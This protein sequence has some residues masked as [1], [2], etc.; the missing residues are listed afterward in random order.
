[1]NVKTE[2]LCIIFCSTS[3][4]FAQSASP[5][6]SIEPVL[7]WNTMEFNSTITL[8]MSSAGLRLPTGRTHGEELL[9]VEFPRIVSPYLFSIPVDS[10]TSIET[11]IQQGQFSILDM[12]LLVGSAKKSPAVLDLAQNSL[13]R[14][15]TVPLT[16]LSALMVRHHVPASLPRPLIPQPSRDYT[17]LIIFAQG[18]LPIYGRQGS[19]RITPCIFPKIW[20]SEGSLIYEKNMVIPEIA[21]TRGIVRYSTIGQVLQNTPSGIA[22]ELQDLV[23]ERPLRILADKVFGKL[24]TDPVI[25][26][27]DALVLLSSDNNR[28]LLQEGRVVI[29]IAQELLIQNVTVSA[30]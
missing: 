24:P 21:K 18:T 27:D 4:L 5:K 20:D 7:N 26:K 25:S 17:G 8:D 23:G 1:M 13:K 29:I 30:P 22:P 14:T 3:L 12:D 9:D 11:A 28:R 2:I 10:T 15:V 6:F 16:N 19:A